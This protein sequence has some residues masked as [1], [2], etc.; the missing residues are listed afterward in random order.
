MASTRNGQHALL[1]AA[2]GVTIAA[3]AFALIRAESQSRLHT[4]EDADWLRWLC[5]D[6]AA[7]VTARNLLAL[8]SGRVKTLRLQYDEKALLK[9]VPSFHRLKGVPRHPDRTLTQARCTGCAASHSANRNLVDAPV[10]CWVR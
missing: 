1:A 7:S 6:D 8:D 2:A 10:H 5:N 9:R 4:L 3:G